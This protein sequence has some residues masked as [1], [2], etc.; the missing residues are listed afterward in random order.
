MCRMI[1]FCICWGARINH[2]TASPNERERLAAL[3]D[4]SFHQA[5][6]NAATSMDGA[7]SEQMFILPP[8][9]PKSAEREN[10]RTVSR[11]V[12]VGLDLDASHPL[13]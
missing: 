3:A 4:R 12:L 11:L 9:P 6:S 5:A 8:S 1:T 7:G 2:R 13:N 10:E